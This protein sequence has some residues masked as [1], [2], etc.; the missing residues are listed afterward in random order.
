MKLVRYIRNGKTGWGK[1]DGG[2]INVLNAPPF[3]GIT[4][5]NE[6]FPLKECSLLAPCEPTKIV[7]VGKNYKEHAL[8]LNSEVPENPIL[9]IKP[10]TSL[11]H[12]EGRIAYP[13]ESARMD[14]EGELAVVVGKQARRVNRK[15]AADYILGYT[16]FN[17]VTARDIQKKDVQWTRAKGFDT[18]GPCGPWIET[19][20]NPQNARIQTRLNGKTM[21]DSNTAMMIWGVYELFEFITAGMTLLPGDVIATGTPSGI[22]PMSPGDFVEV[23]IDGIGILRNTVTGE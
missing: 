5:G 14:Y 22:G 21:Q 7:C 10:T 13:R 17:D 9:F 1:L 20:I 19:E 15:D 8:E 23:E 12:P 3:G 11:N 6:V 18:F 2:S 4:W 16:C